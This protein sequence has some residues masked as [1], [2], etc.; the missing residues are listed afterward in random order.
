[1]FGD[2]F[3]VDP[4]TRQFVNE[5]IVLSVQLFGVAARAVLLRTVVSD[6]TLLPTDRAEHSRRPP[7]GGS[8]WTFGNPVTHLSAHVT[9]LR[10]P[11]RTIKNSDLL[12]LTCSFRIID[13]NQQFGHHLNT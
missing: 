5:S 3:I 13:R 1:M 11:P 4:R 7:F 9:G 8:I 6:M 12:H 2:S 10:W